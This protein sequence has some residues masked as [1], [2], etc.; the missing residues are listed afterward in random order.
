[1]VNVYQP[2]TSV[3]SFLTVLEELTKTLR[4]VVYHKDLKRALSHGLMISQLH[5]ILNERMLVVLKWMLVTIR[6]VCLHYNIIPFA[7]DFKIIATRI[8]VGV[9]PDDYGRFFRI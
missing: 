1:M 3:I 6:K 2:V 5:I 8:F 9:D 7:L 4:R